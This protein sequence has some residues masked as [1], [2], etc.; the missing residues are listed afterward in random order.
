[1]NQTIKNIA[2]GLLSVLFT[3][4]IIEMTLRLIDRP[5]NFMSG[6][7]PCKEYSECNYLGFRGKQ[8]AYSPDD[9]VVLLVG[10]SQVV[11]L[12]L[13]FEQR[14]EII[15]ENH[16]KKYRKNV[17]VFTIGTAGY[18]Q[19]QQLLILEKYF[20]RHRADLVL[21]FHSTITD[22]YNN[23]Y[24]VSGKDSA[25]KPTF[26]LEDGNIR[27]PTEGWLEPVGSRFKLKLLWQMHVGKTPGEQ[28]SDQWEESILPVS[29]KAL[30]EYQGEVDYSWQEQWDSGN[31]LGLEN[32]NSERNGFAGWLTPRSNRMQYGIDLMQKLLSKMKELT[33]ANNSQF[34]VFKEENQETLDYVKDKRTHF[35]NGKYYILTLKQY[36]DNLK[37]LFRNYEFYNIPLKMDN[38]TMSED[39][40][41]LNLEANNKLM[42]ELSLIISNK[43]YFNPV[44]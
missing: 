43:K 13:P 35:L 14:P 44:N 36:Q 8:I 10:D 23:I 39:N 34:I 11:A 24:P 26:W 15:L 12:S 21:L 4:L 19:D 1:M 40:R 18:G 29:Y 27:G 16:L 32:I 20:E 28:R 38:Y 42:E 6:W 41:H 9:F 22:I 31:R 33:E 3:L 30:S 5:M 25:V 37:D 17:K 2:V 7:N